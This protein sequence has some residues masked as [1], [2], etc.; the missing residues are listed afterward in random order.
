MSGRTRH[1]GFNEEWLLAVALLVAPDDAETPALVV[2]LMQ[3]DVPAPVHVAAGEKIKESAH[4]LSC[5]DGRCL[6]NGMISVVISSLNLC[7]Y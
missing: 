1:D 7:S 6:K 2:G 3:D 4:K 5:K